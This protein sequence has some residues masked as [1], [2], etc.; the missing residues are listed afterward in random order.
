MK[1]PYHY[2]Y[3]C[4]AANARIK[5][6]HD[7]GLILFYRACNGGKGLCIRL[8]LKLQVLQEAGVYFK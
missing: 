6:S 5:R 2:I 1:M 3:E 4:I 7:F 8:L